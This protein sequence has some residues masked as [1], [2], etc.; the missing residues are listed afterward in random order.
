MVILY[1][2]YRGYIGILLGLYR[3]NGKDNGSYYL[4]LG[5][6]RVLRFRV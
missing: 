4:W 2:L 1:W 5:G 6:F 3:D